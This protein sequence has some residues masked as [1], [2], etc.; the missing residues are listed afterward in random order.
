MTDKTKKQNPVL[1]TY[2][3]KSDGA[4]VI[5]QEELS[6]EMK[7]M[8]GIVSGKPLIMTPKILRAEN[9][10]EKYDEIL[11]RKVSKLGNSGHI[12]IPSKHIGKTAQV[13]IQKEKEED[14][15]K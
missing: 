1:N 14:K 3:R 7:E 2:Y 8:M 5:T 4:S 13:L 9:P 15:K 12:S 10:I 6:P 11:M